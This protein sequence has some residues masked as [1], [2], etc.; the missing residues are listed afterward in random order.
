MLSFSTRTTSKAINNKILDMKC[1]FDVMRGLFLSF[2][3]LMLQKAAI[4]NIEHILSLLAIAKI[5]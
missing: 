2:Q 4:R 5:V 3:K 1:K